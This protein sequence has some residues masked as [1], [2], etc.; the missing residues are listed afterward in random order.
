M[1]VKN[2]E[3]LTLAVS[4][5]TQFG[6]KHLRCRIVQAIEHSQPR[7]TDMNEDLLLSYV[8]ELRV[9]PTDINEKQRQL[10]KEHIVRKLI[11]NSK[12]TKY[13]MK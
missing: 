4:T 1:D 13:L 5:K 9:Q 2:V 10:S 6:L 3:D 11:Y 8:R 12:L 7:M